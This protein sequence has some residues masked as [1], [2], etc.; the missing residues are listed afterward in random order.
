MF[1]AVLFIIARSWKKNR[2]P[3]TEDWIQI[4]WKSYTMGY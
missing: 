4:M 1:I 3:P 2:F